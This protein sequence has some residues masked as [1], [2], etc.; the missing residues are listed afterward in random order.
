M[1]LRLAFGYRLWSYGMVY[2][3]DWAGWCLGTFAPLRRTGKFDVH[4]RIPSITTHQ[5][6]C[7]RLVHVTAGRGSTE[8]LIPAPPRLKRG[9]DKRVA[10]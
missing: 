4:L 2:I 1:R 6:I 8:G 7:P 10:I 3:T 9:I 5:D